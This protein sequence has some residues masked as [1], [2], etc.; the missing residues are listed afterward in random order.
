MPQWTTTEHFNVSAT[1]S[2]SAP[3]VYLI[4]MDA[5]A[6]PRYTPIDSYEPGAPEDG[7]VRA[8]PDAPG[9]SPA[10]G[11]V[12]EVR[13]FRAGRRVTRERIVEVV[14]DRRMVYEMLSGQTG[15]F[16]GYRGQVD[17]QPQP[18]GGTLIRWG[19]TWRS[20]LP[21]VGWLVARLM[22]RYFQRN[23]VQGLARYA[24]EA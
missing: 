3:A 16:R 11:P 1:T 17:L 4:L 24:E 9:G 13:V 20:P 23:M 12:G 8:G 18:D 6:V 19:A 15:M 5:S 21:G 2:A 14:Q 7:D 10:T 22:G